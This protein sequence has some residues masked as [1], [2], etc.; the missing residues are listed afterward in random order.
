L[1][2]KHILRESVSAGTRTWSVSLGLGYWLDPYL[3][4]ALIFMRIGISLRV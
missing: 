2:D 1:R 3:P 4:E